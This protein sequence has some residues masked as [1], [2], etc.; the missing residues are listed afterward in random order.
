MM[1]KNTSFRQLNYDPGH[2]ILELY[3]DLVQIW[4]A[5]SKQNLISG[6]TNLEYKFI[7]CIRV[8]THLPPIHPLKKTAPLFLS[9]PPFKPTKCPTPLN[10]KTVQ[11][12][13]FLGN[14]PSIL[15][16]RKSPP[17]P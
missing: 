7:V 12:P 9:T 1:F 2:N 3:N 11:A 13:S 5:T 8:S 16:F 4:F 14:P 15:V 6:I 17:P 10:L